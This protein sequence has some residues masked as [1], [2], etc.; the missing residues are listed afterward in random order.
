MTAGLP[1]TA[2]TCPVCGA[3]HGTLDEFWACP[4]HGHQLQLEGIAEDSRGIYTCP[5][6]RCRYQRT[7]LRPKPE[8]EPMT[9]IHHPIPASPSTELVI[10]DSQGFWDAKQRAAL[11]QLGIH[12]APNADLAVFF[13]YCKAHRLDPFSHQATMIKRRE[14]Q[15][16]DNWVDKWTIQ[17]EIDGY[18]VIAHRA[19]NRDGKIISYRPTIWVDSDGNEHRRWVRPEPPAGAEVTVLVD[20]APFTGY[21]SYREF[22]PLHPRSGKPMGLWEKMPANQT[23]KC[24]EAQALR[25]AFPRDLGGTET[26]D[27]TAHERTISWEDHATRPSPS[28]PRPSNE[29]AKQEGR[30]Q[31]AGK[32]ELAAMDQLLRSLQLGPGTDVNMLL[33]WLCQAPF[34]G[35]RDD[36]Q[37]VTSFLQRHLEAAGGDT[38]EA[39]SAIWEEYR[40]A[41]DQDAAEASGDTPGDGDE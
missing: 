32:R 16:D 15:G 4:R 41:V 7:A 8:K 24:A 28:E 1:I 9:T 36:V 12:D 37:R 29:V 35:S 17:T 10:K 38:A 39:A 21:A 40:A 14:R 34:S 31:R 27:E 11:T 5:A 22:V 3:V 25:K 20:G 13:H 33:E 26:T 30:P 2:D 19:A 18:R 23:A 6:H